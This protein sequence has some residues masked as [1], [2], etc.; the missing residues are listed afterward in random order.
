M[1]PDEA[2]RATGLSVR[3]LSRLADAGRLRTIRP[4]T[5][6]RYLTQDVAAIIAQDA[7]WSPA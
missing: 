6:R 4:G 2:A 1:T 7:D 3:Q 5:H